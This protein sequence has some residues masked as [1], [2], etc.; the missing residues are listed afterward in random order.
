M[1]RCEFLSHF[2]HLLVAAHAYHARV[3]ARMALNPPWFDYHNHFLFLVLCV[4]WSFPISN[5]VII[6]LIKA[7]KQ[8]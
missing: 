6:V 4:P 8:G 5:V 1:G 7:D 2:V 3:N